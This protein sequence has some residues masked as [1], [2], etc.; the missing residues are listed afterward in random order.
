MKILHLSDLH[1]GKRVNE[2]SLIEDQ[3][4]ILNAILDIVSDI[5]PDAVVIAGD[6][7]DKSLPSAEAV[8]VLDDFLFRLS[9]FNKPVMIVSGNHDSP[10][11][12]AFGNRLISLSGIRISSAYCGETEKVTLSDRF[13]EVDFYMLPYIKPAA[14]K[15][16][17]DGEKIESFD[18]ALNA[19]VKRMNVDT[20]KR[21]VLIAHQFVTGGERSESEET[22]VG[23][24]D[25]VDASV[26][27]VFDYVALGHLHRP[28]NVAD[29]MRYCGTPIKYSF[30]EVHDRKSVSV[31]EL[32]EKGN[33]SISTVE[34]KPLRDMKEIKG[35]Y[36]E[37]TAKSFYEGTTLT[38]DYVHITL[39][40]ENDVLDAYA[41]LRSIYKN[42]M[43]IDYDNE[44]TRA[45]LC[46]IGAAAV[47]EKSPYTLVNE[48]FL[49][50]NN[51]EMTE[52][53]S[54]TVKKL[55][56]EIWGEEDETD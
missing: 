27:S 29:N 41:R 3:K 12:L 24:L 43:K 15:R 19:C 16:F 4:F 21:N 53:Q 14:V 40:D 47:E 36:E 2:F 42:L 38:D 39:T 20:A 33:V 8:E 7:Y 35:T 10:E 45:A 49:M 17:F 37:L 9:L 56:E 46:G 26:F 1:I 55:I 30:S 28:Q 25:N 31:V 23:G 6:V 32:N 34:L 50:Q 54:E 52:K 18:D 22:F 51:T 48:L 5:S 44:R 13:G 11:R